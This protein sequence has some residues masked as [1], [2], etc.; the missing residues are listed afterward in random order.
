M[1]FAGTTLFRQVPKKL[2]PLIS[3]G[4]YEAFLKVMKC[5]ISVPFICS[6]RCNVLMVRPAA[7]TSE[8]EP[9]HNQGFVSFIS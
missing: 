3:L 2:V 5:E 1:T 4:R 6:R 7:L 9:D 8:L